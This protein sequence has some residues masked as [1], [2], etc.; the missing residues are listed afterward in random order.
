[1][2]ELKLCRP[3]WNQFHICHYFVLTP[4]YLVVLHP[5]G[6]LHH[7]FTHSQVLD[8]L[9]SPSVKCSWLIPRWCQ[10][11]SCSAI[12]TYVLLFWFFCLSPP[13]SNIWAQILSW[14]EHTVPSIWMDSWVHV[15][16]TQLHRSAIEYA[17]SSI[18]HHIWRKLRLSQPDIIS[19]C[20]SRNTLYSWPFFIYIF[21]TWM[22]TVIFMLSYPDFL[23]QHSQSKHICMCCP[24][25]KFGLSIVVE[26]HIS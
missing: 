22:P 9:C 4:V 20:L 26:Q 8:S 17:L 7:C 16:L 13:E 2:P 11:W 1:M 21:I 25:F 15:I 23:R 19:G 14:T 10:T 6:L 24:S 12:L 5:L 18:V 3:F